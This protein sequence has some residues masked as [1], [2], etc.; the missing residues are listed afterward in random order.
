MSDYK[1][2]EIVETGTVKRLLAEMQYLDSKIVGRL[3]ILLSPENIKNLPN[4]EIL[5]GVSDEIIQSHAEILRSQAGLK[6]IY[7]MIDTESK[8][9]AVLQDKYVALLNTDN[10]FEGKKEIF[11][12]MLNDVIGEV[13]Q[14]IDLTKIDISKMEEVFQKK[15]EESYMNPL[16]SFVNDGKESILKAYS[17]AKKARDIVT[18]IKESINTT[19]GTLDMITI[20]KMDMLDKRIEEITESVDRME[21]VLSSERLEGIEKRLTEAEKISTK[22]LNSWQIF[23]VATLCFGM[24]ILFFGGVLTMIPEEILISIV[25]RDWEK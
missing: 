17:V 3:E 1:D 23:M 5:K 25:N 15:F 21:E 18:E 4:V 20:H 9:I 24:G 11:Q 10:A 13:V 2:L 8:R 7:G 14:S 16:T 12:K 19:M 6:S 22:K